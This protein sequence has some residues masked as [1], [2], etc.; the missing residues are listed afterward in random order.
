M[1]APEA[2]QAPRPVLEGD[3][4]SPIDPPAGCHFHPRCRFA[5]ARCRTEAPI[6][7]ADGTGHAVACHHWRELPAWQGLSPALTEPP[8]PHLARLI[9]RFRQSKDVA[10]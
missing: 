7:E 3:L 8:P 1:P 6:L 9:D 5:T 2:G 4:P 10:A